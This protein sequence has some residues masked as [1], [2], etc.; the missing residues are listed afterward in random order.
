MLFFDTMSFFDPIRVTPFFLEDRIKP[1]ND[2]WN[3][4]MQ[5]FDIFLV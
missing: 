4:T 2:V 3:K 1:Y 5:T